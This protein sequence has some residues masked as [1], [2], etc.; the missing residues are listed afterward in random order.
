MQKNRIRIIVGAGLAAVSLMGLGGTALAGGGEVVKSDVTLKFS[1]TEFAFKGKVVS[2]KGACE[3]KRVVRV[4]MKKE[5]PDQQVALGVTHSGG[6]YQDD[7]AQ[8]SNGVKYY[9]VAEEKDK[10]F[11]CK[12][13]RSPNFVKTS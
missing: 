11:L 9:A 2:A 13:A 6:R 8:V 4:F 5:G 7:V 3:R 12:E 1:D 10:Q